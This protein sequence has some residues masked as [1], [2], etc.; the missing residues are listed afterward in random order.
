MYTIDL[1]QTIGYPAE[2]GRRTETE[3][4]VSKEM[5]N[6]AR[7]NK[8]GSEYVRTLNDNNNI[9][10]LEEEWKNRRDFQDNINSTTKRVSNKIPS[11]VNYALVKTTHSFWADS[12][13]IDIIVFGDSMKLLRRE[14]VDAGY[15]LCG[16]SPSSFDVI[17]PETGIQIDIQSQF[18]LQ[19]VTY[20]Q[21]E[22]IEDRVS[23]QNIAGATIPVVA[24]PDDLALIVIHSIT[25]QL[26]ILKE[27]YAALYTL[28]GF[29][30]E[31]YSRFIETVEENSIG[32]ACQAFFTLVDELSSEAFQKRPSYLDDILERYP[33][34][35]QERTKLRNEGFKTP[36]QYT[37]KTTLRT[38]TRKL[39][40]MKFLQSLLVQAPHL[41]RP[42]KLHYI[43][44]QLLVRREREHYMH[45]T[46]DFE[47][48]Q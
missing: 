46:T 44:S 13:D 24:K 32:P 45:D 41:L 31:D 37:R 14:L 11:R 25:E 17:D 29:S 40:N 19:H 18:S 9:G 5:Y 1:L 21:K 33:P 43:G 10:I 6:L 38:V 27:F 16:E 2:P 35:E 36:H 23:E 8:I 39:T 42:S 12:K 30:E 20:F 15:E 3:L 34:F 26:F 28:D 4:T 48:G 7:K 22:T 47:E